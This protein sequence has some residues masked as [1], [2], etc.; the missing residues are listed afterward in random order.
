M[1]V[2]CILS[3]KTFIAKTRLHP[4]FGGEWS[5][6]ILNMIAGDLIGH[7][8]NVQSIKFDGEVP[9]L[10]LANDIKNFNR[11][12][13]VGSFGLMNNNRFSLNLYKL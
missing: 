7:F 12:N 1:K 3:L 2:M 6:E 13:L 4:K 9:N 11:N 5:C 8:S 10:V